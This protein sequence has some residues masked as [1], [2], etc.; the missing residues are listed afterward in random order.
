ME[1]KGGEGGGKKNKL[2]CGVGEWH[3]FCNSLWKASA[4]KKEMAN[5]HMLAMVS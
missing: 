3:L 1:K 5:L 4:T 2:R